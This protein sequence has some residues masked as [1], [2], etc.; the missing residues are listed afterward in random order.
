MR[1]V[2]VVCPKCRELVP[3]IE[4]TVQEHGECPVG[5]MRYVPSPRMFKAGAGGPEFEVLATRPVIKAPCEDCKR[6]HV[7]G[8]EVLVRVNLPNPGV[9]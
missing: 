1:H 7:A 8:I 6:E 9:N 4:K 3:V 2:S 5:G